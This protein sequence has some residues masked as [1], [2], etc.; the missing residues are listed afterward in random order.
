VRLVLVHARAS[1]LQLARYPTFAVP[2]LLFPALLYAFFGLTQSSAR[3]NILMASFAAYAVLS[4]AFFQ[5]GVGIASDRVDPW[6]T[7]VRTLPVGAGVRFAAR[8]VSALAFAIA[9]AAVVVTLALAATPARLSGVEWGR[10]ALALLA[11]G[12]PLAL[13]GIAVGYWV[14]PKAALA[15]ANVLYL[16]FAY[17]GGLWTGPYRL[18]HAVESAAPFVPTR[19]WGDVVWASVDSGGWGGV[20]WL[21]LMAYGVLFGALAVLG[22]RRDEGERFG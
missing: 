11:G 13:L 4:V 6:E 3:A 19:Q 16:A 7:F 15:V 21:A 17:A 20:H 12:V 22:Y 10:F 1:L 5:F 18:P 8:V 14:P 9:S 2:T